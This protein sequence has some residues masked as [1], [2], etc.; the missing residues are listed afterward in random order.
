MA[1]L[2]QIVGAE[3]TALERLIDDYLTSCRAR[4]LANKTVRLVYGP[5]LIRKFAPW[6][7]E[8]GIGHIEDVTQRLVDRWSAGLYE[9]GLK[10]TSIHSYSRTLNGFLSW[11]RKE[12]ERVVARGQLPKLPQRVVRTLS[13]QEIQ[14]IEDHASNERDALIVRLL[15]DTGIRVGELCALRVGDLSPR[16]TQATLL[17]TGKGAKQRQVPLTPALAD[18]VRRHVRRR[19]E[20]ARTDHVFLTLQRSK[21]GDHVALQPSGVLQLIREL[22]FK[23]GISGLHP[24][25]FRHSYATHCLAQNMNIEVLRRILGHEDTTL[26]SRTYGHLVTADIHRAAMAVLAD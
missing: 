24:H 15:A 26:I 16:T 8:Q 13:R 10:P 3:P 14:R 22:G 9:Q 12:G 1:D 6:A 20:D 2:A 11:A 23:A 4:G 21:V 19:P 7:R 18:R 5:V 17:I 25:L